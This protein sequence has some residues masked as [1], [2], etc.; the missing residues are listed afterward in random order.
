[1]KKNI[2][3]L[4]LSISILF[5]ISCFNKKQT[6]ETPKPIVSNSNLRLAGAITTN[7]YY[8]N[9][10][11]NE[12]SFFVRYYPNEASPRPLIIAFHGGGFIGGDKSACNLP[13]KFNMNSDAMITNLITADQLDNQG[14]VYASANYILLAK[15]KNATVLNSLTDCKDFLNYMIAN[16]ATYN[17]DPN[18]IILIGN[19]GGAAASLWIGLQNNNIKGIVAIN[20]QAT[21][22]ILEWRNQ[23]FA[24]FGATSV[25]DYGFINNP[26]PQALADYASLLYGTTNQTAINNYCNTNHLS[27]FN[28]FDSSDPEL[29]MACGALASDPIHHSAHDW[30]LKQKSA[31]AGHSARILYTNAPQFWNTYQ[32]SVIQFCIR[33]FQ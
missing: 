2:Q 14:Y 8:K 16:A 21:L 23:V 4:L 10:G 15:G 27:L 5:C 17:I 32:E 30:A 29:Y 13:L 33:K 12:N 20:P 6:E 3:P 1:M 11:N 7:G 18:K 24:P 19:S 31:A 28:L 9:P 26:N 22:N 25:F